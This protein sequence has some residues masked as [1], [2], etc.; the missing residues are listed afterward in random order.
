MAY[1]KYGAKSPEWWKHLKESKRRFWKKVRNAD[2]EEIEQEPRSDQPEYD[3][4][5]N[6]CEDLHGLEK[7]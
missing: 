2:K 6:E 1:A 3:N 7:P 5:Q 4:L